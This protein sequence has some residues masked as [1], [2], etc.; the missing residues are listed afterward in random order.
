[1]DV[2]FRFPFE[3]GRGKQYRITADDIVELTKKGKELA[4]NE[5]FS[6][7]RAQVLMAL[8]DRGSTSVKELSNDTRLPIDKVKGVV[9]DL[10][11]RASVRKVGYEGG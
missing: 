9:V 2:K 11:N 1:M 6:G 3:V 4:E 10:M 8:N 5:A 7:S